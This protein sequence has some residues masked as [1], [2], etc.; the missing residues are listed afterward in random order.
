MD[1]ESGWR[2]CERELTAQLQEARGCEKKLQDEAR[3]LCLRAKAAQESAGQAGLQLSEAQGRLAATE[4]EL[5]RAEAGRRDL[6]FRL[7]SL[8]SAL[9]RTLGIGA[10]RRVS[11][12]G[13]G[14]RGRSPAGSSPGSSTISR[15]SSTSPLRSSLSPRKGQGSGGSHGTT[16]HMV[17]E[18][19]AVLGNQYY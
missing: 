12:G 7:G 4:A 11:G 3:N 10:G 14:G 8:Q 9:T 15:H 5:T 17:A 16:C 6:E 19:I 18:Y 13:G 1:S 2:G